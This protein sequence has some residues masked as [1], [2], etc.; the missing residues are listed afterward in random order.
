MCRQKNKSSSEALQFVGMALFGIALALAPL[1]AAE[2]D[3]ELI[4][5]IK[6][7][8][9]ADGVEVAI[10]GLTEADVK[11]AVADFQERILED[12]L[13]HETV[14][15]SRPLL[16]GRYTDL[17][18]GELDKKLRKI[19]KAHNPEEEPD[20]WFS[21][22]WL[23]DHAGKKHAEKIDGALKES[24]AKYF[25]KNFRSARAKAVEEQRAKIARGVY[26]ESEEVDYL[27][28]ARWDNNARGR[29]REK[30]LKRM[31]KGT[32]LEEV[33]QET[34]KIGDESI[35]QAR[36]QMQDQLDVVD[37]ATPQE[38]DIS[39]PQLKQSLETALDD[40]IDEAKRQEPGEMV[41][42]RF[43][44]VLDRIDKR[45][46][47][48]EK[49]RFRSFMRTW[50]VTISE[51]YLRKT[52][53]GEP[54][55]HKD[56]DDSVDRVSSGIVPLEARKCIAS[57]ADEPG[58]GLEREEFEKRLEN[59][60]DNDPALQKNVT[61]KVKEALPKTREK[62]ADEQF[63]KYFPKV[64]SDEW[65]APEKYIRKA[66]E[67]TRDGLADLAKTLDINYCLE[68]LPAIDEDGQPFKR[69]E[70]LKETEDALIEKCRKLLVEAQAAWDEQLLLVKKVAKPV[71]EDIE[72]DIRNGTPEDPEEYEGRLR[73]ETQKEWEQR[74]Y[75]KI[76]PRLRYPP[77]YVDLFEYTEERIE[78]IVSVKFKDV[79]A[80][81]ATEK[82][83]QAEREAREARVREAI[84]K[85]RRI[86]SEEKQGEDGDAAAREALEKARLL[87]LEQEQGE[88]GDAAA[89]KALE[90]ARR[91]AREREEQE[92]RRRAEQQAAMA[93]KNEGK[94]KK[95]S[96]EGPVKD[97]AQD[98]DM[99]DE[100]DVEEG[101]GRQRGGPEKG[102]TRED[103]TGMG[104]GGTIQWP[105]PDV[106][107][108]P[109]AEVPPD[110]PVD[111]TTEEPE[112]REPEEIDDVL[113]ALDEPVT[114]RGL[115]LITDPD[116]EKGTGAGWWTGRGGMFL[117]IF[118]G[119][120]LTYL[121]IMIIGFIAASLIAR[122]RKSNQWK[123]VITRHVEDL[124]EAV[125]FY[126]GFG[127]AQI[128]SRSAD[129]AMIRIG[130]TYVELKKS[131][132]DERPDE[133]ISLS[134][135]TKKQKKAKKYIEARGRPG[136]TRD[137]LLDPEGMPI[138]V[139]NN[140]GLLKLFGNDS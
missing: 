55:K 126:K 23:K 17:L 65:E 70:L 135:A 105:A 40:A 41:Y 104:I 54:G 100:E 53:S 103:G 78:Q 92:A 71:I 140:D 128:T 107:K 24:R 44:S 87:R 21:L 62:I 47:E 59:Y 60:A 112:E 82:R 9:A 63:K 138:G 31:S 102:G 42:A 111:P 68:Q 109:P 34:E 27:H 19:W 75:K 130:D 86:A 36:D 94:T 136:V 22:E 67:D 6:Q 115:D 64:A 123:M 11:D 98:D 15:Q 26:P 81:I 91:L 124:P 134:V 131:D 20:K 106:P 133:S 46:A 137:Q 118:I 33:R 77:K 121:I 76:W 38:V 43:K 73:K 58:E 29:I 35:D 48:L 99:E 52:I 93:T 110:L 12:T 114:D 3:T 119:V 51:D 2:A 50:E 84:E 120:S 125:R 97:P 30:L 16:E 122:H 79:K 4:E 96:E 10:D 14:D 101:P 45:A 18:K 72:A 28:G 88:D 83:D 66:N 108:R 49:E 32:M 139:R 69:Q 5:K 90:K 8:L 25:E 37:K 117:P 89:Q 39:R 57:Y 1:R 85:A 80:W 132:G 95:P 116:S 7:N 74:G 129:G 56:F 13:A 127:G 61:Q 113:V